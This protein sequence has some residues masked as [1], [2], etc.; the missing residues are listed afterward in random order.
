MIMT[1]ELTPLA[2]LLVTTISVAGDWV[3]RKDIGFVIGRPKGNL[4]PYDI[5]ILDSLE[6]NGRIESRKQQTGTVRFEYQ[7]RAKGG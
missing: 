7:Y 5:S 4:T 6:A 3:T 2:Q 1:S